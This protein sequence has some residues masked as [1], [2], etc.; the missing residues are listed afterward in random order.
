MDYENVLEL[1]LVTNVLRRIILDN[2]TT[3]PWPL[4]LGVL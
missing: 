1:K 3:Y 2:L 4:P